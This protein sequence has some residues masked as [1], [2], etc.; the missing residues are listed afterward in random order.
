MTLI[1]IEHLLNL[2]STVTGCSFNSAFAFLVGA[3][4]GIVSFSVGIKVC[5]IT[6]GIN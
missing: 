2:A 3:H 4:A 5:A 6:T 1:Y